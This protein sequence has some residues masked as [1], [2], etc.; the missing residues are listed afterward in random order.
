[1]L[2]IYHIIVIR[3]EATLVRMMSSRVISTS[4]VA[5]PLHGANFDIFELVVSVIV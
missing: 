1:M 4:V 3:P 2:R 5:L